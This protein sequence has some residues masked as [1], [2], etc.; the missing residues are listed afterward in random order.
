MTVIARPDNVTL[1][2]GAMQNWSD[3]EHR[4][5]GAAAAVRALLEPLLRHDAR[6][7]VVGPH[8]L[9]LVTGIAGR[10]GHLTVFTRSIPD[11][12]TFGQALTDHDAQVVCGSLADLPEPA[13]TYDLVVALDDVTRVLSLETAVLTWA[14]TFAGIRRLVAP[15]GTLL[16]AVEQELGLH[17]I[18]ALRSRFTTNTDA[19]WSVTATYDRSRPRSV[20]ALSALLSDAGL[21]VATS[22]SAFPSWDDQQ[23]VAIDPTRLDPAL[24]TLLGAVTT[25]SPAFRRL[26]SDPTRVARAAVLSGRLPELASAWIVVAGTPHAGGAGT[27]HAGR[28]GEPPRASRIETT[29]PQVLESTSAGGVVRYTAAAGDQ[30]ERATVDGEQH[31]T[32]TVRPDARLFTDDLLDA[33]A[34]SEQAEL[35]RLLRAYAERVRTWGADGTLPAACSDV[36]PDNLLLQ[37]DELE[38]IAPGAGGRSPEEALWQGLGDLVQV[39]RARGARHP[40]PS[41]TDDRTMLALLGSM[42]GLDLPDDVERFVAPVEEP[43]LP[44]YDVPGLLAVIERLEE[45]NAALASRAQWFEDRLNTREREM[46]S[47]SALHE[48]EMRRAMQQQ[49]T[50]RRSAEDVRRSITYRT[51]NL[52]I[53][54]LRRIKG[55]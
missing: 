20:E 13:E 54:P 47:R 33:A 6:V 45:T 49:E 5:A 4:P 26:G 19:D 48:Q 41:A 32:I 2:P 24:T 42:A 50:L 38:P 21:P 44:A 39:I 30:V 35:R 31:S 9:D 23:V 14:E 55:D 8:A 28:V 25:G 27:P 7:A 34:G 37:G 12:I 36:R 18:A 51:G 16:L 40:W 17:R 15:G 1:V 46:R 11:A 53:G 43:T 3:L 10:V 22:A 52:V 29:G